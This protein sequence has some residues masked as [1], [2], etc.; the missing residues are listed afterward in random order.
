M[1]ARRTVVRTGAPAGRCVGST[2]DAMA[3]EDATRDDVMALFDALGLCP[4]RLPLD[5]SLAHN[6]GTKVPAALHREPFTSIDAMNSVAPGRVQVCGKD[7]QVEVENTPIS[8]LVENG[9]TVIMDDVPQAT[10]V[11]H[12]LADVLGLTHAQVRSVVFINAPGSGLS[13]HHDP[14]DALIFQ[15]VGS[16]SLHT[17]RHPIVEQP[18]VQYDPNGV[19]HRE[20]ERVVETYGQSLP[21]PVQELAGH[22]GWQTHALRPGS[23]LFL[24]AGVWHHTSKQP[25]RNMSI[26]FLFTAPTVADLLGATLT[27]TMRQ[28]PRLRQRVYGA[29]NTAPEGRAHALATVHEGL[30]EL[31][32]ALPSIDASSLLRTAYPTIRPQNLRECRYML[33]LDRLLDVHAEPDGSVSLRVQDATHGKTLAEYSFEDASVTQ[34]FTRMRG[35]CRAFCV[36]ELVDGTH[37]NAEDVFEL[38]EE[39]VPAALSRAPM[40]PWP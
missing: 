10:S 24:P 25:H 7:A 36:G 23:A 21:P 27:R 26:T 3:S 18:A 15:L 9:F 6:L 20:F 38:L 37:A 2:L 35:F 19:S 33:R 30:S 5:V 1:A 29:L 13:V 34:L 40:Q 32:R 22:R 4:W 8:T 11:C 28:S 17:L 14:Y 39:L 16:K 12:N 31:G